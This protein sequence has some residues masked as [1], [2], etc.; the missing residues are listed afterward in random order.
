MSLQSLHLRAYPCLIAQSA[1]GAFVNK[2]FRSDQSLYYYIL[3]WIKYMEAYVEL[4]LS[5]VVFLVDAEGVVFGQDM[6]K[7]PFSLIH[8]NGLII[9][10]LLG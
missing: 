3:I 5:V 9:L 6:K 10:N 2:V 8:E 1:D 7:L 4:Y